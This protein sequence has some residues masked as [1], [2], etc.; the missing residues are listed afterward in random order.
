MRRVRTSASTAAASS[1]EAGSRSARTPTATYV[2]ATMRSPPAI[3]A[4]ARRSGNCSTV[5]PSCREGNGLG[6]CECGTSTMPTISAAATTVG[7]LERQRARTRDFGRR[8]RAEPLVVL[9]R[10]RAISM[11]C[12]LRAAIAGGA[13]QLGRRA[14]GRR[15]WI[16]DR[17]DEADAAAQL[18]DRV[19]RNVALDAAAGDVAHDDRVT[20]RADETSTPGNRNMPRR[21]FDHVVPITGLGAIEVRLRVPTHPRGGSDVESRGSRSKRRSSS[22]TPATAVCQSSP[23]PLHS[24]TSTISPSCTGTPVS[25]ASRAR[26]KPLTFDDGKPG[27][28]VA[29]ALVVPHARKR[30]GLVGIAVARPQRL[31]LDAPALTGPHRVQPYATAA[32]DL[33]LTREPLFRRA[34]IRYS[35]PPRPSRGSAS[36]APTNWMSPVWRSPPVVSRTDSSVQPRLPQ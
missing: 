19:G 21:T 26:S 22:A 36:G 20:R 31:A 8:T 23:R 32:K 15:E 17:L 29:T 18:A 4:G 6:S 1:L 9:E 35:A 13:Q 16:A 33:L 25:G 5:S 27:A 12:G 11:A 34:R 7:A 30:E 2:G 28:A 14:A 3:P 10:H 24:R